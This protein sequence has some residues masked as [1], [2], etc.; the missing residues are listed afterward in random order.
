MSSIPDHT[1]PVVNRRWAKWRRVVDLETYA[2]RFDEMAQ[3]GEHPH[4]EADAVSRLLAHDGS[5]LDAGC[6]MGRIAMELDRRGFDVVGLDV[7]PDMLGRA[8]TQRPD[9]R[10]E[11][12]DAARV[13]LGRTFDLVLL[14]GNVM[15]YVPDGTE[16]EVVAT[17]GR[18]LAPGGILLSGFSLGGMP[19]SGI[20]LA[21]YD[22]FCA[23]NGLR[24]VDRWA[25]WKGA[26][27]T[28]EAAGSPADYAVS[29][30]RAPGDPVSRGQAGG[31]GRVV[32][33]SSSAS[34]RIASA[35]PRTAP[36]TPE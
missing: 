14:A 35:T 2:N 7:D 13:D 1:D 4:G 8:R 29:I 17:M 19:V 5:V 31:G 12:A 22:S 27:Y 26:P 18:H 11:L 9:M 10:W 6:G 34:L 30:H 21:T 36:S 20:S 23:D 3:G 28:G 16:A 15:I 25:T 32:R 24:L 33:S